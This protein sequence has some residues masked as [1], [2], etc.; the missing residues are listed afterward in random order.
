MLPRA[1]RRRPGASGGSELQQDEGVEDEEDPEKDRPTVEVALDQRT[2]AERTAALTDTEGA[3]EPR[4]LARV[5]EHQEDQDH[6]D[7]HLDDVE[8][9]FHRAPV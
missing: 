8:N 6:R 7:Q 3:R 1:R 4:V 5:Q 9:A 2:A